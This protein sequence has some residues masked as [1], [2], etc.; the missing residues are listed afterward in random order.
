[1]LVPPGRTN[2]AEFANVSAPAQQSQ[3][4]LQQTN[5]KKVTISI[6]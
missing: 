4:N 3:Q 1:M 5:M 2:V 6:I